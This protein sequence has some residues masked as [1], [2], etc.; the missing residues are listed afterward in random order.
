VPVEARH[1][2]STPGSVVRATGNIRIKVTTTYPGKCFLGVYA[3][4]LRGIP[5]EL[6]YALETERKVRKLD[7]TSETV[8]SIIKEY[9]QVVKSD[10]LRII[11]G[12]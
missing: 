8:F 7:T 6:V 10:D 4:S 1:P 2:A 9:F 5:D 11:E 3:I 12:Y